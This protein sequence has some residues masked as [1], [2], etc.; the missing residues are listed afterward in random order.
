MSKQTDKIPKLTW[1]YISAAASLFFLV[2]AV[3]MILFAPGISGLG[4]T[5]SF[6]Y[7]ILIPVGLASAAFLFG[8]L[9][10]G[11]K[12]SGKN[13]FGSIELTGPVVIFCLVVIGGI[14]FAPPE[15][16]FSLTV[17][18]SVSN[19]PEKI[20][21]NGNVIID[22]G[23]QRIKKQLNENGEVSFPGISSRYLGKNVIIIPQ[24]TR[25][26]I[27]GKNSFIIPDD[28]IIYVELE[29]RKDSTLLR[30]RV[31]N[32]S[33]DPIDSVF[34]DIESGFAS[35]MTDARGNFNVVVPAAKGETVLLSALKNGA[36]GYREY[37]TVPDRGSIEI[38]FRKGL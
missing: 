15:S 1:V 29:E 22:I 14:Y 37:I 32:E 34:I 2:L 12:Y 4:I 38:K 5:K 31:I 24:I 20:I 25:Y 6:Y 7:L 26:K 21:N 27:K 35:A 36:T 10:S 33:G 18:T 28:R 17:R 11:A 13:S 8:A 23:E 30:G 19:E 3:L 9:R 16:D